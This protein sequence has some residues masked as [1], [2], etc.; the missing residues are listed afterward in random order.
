MHCRSEFSG[1]T[2]IKRQP[3]R[4]GDHARD[5]RASRSRWVTSW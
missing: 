1:G 4:A 5:G 2:G 3:A